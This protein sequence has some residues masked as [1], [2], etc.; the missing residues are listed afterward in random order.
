MD[1]ELLALKEKVIMDLLKIQEVSDQLLASCT[2]IRTVKSDELIAFGELRAVL[3]QLVSDFVKDSQ[4][5]IVYP[6]VPMP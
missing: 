4:T 1:N 5:Y 2:N 6:N 3:Q